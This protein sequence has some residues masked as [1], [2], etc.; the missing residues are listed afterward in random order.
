MILIPHAQ[1]KFLEMV[2]VPN[3]IKSGSRR[4]LRLSP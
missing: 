4:T 3:L 1:E 2:F